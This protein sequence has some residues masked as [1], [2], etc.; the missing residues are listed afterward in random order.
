LS[1][2]VSR[3]QNLG[4]LAK[5][6]N[7]VFVGC[8]NE[9]N[10]QESVV[11]RDTGGTADLRSSQSPE[12]QAVRFAATIDRTN[13]AHAVELLAAGSLD[14]AYDLRHLPKQKIGTRTYAVSLLR[15][16]EQM[17]GVRLTLL[18]REP[19][20]ADGF[21]HRIVTEHEWNDDV[22]VIHRPAQIFDVCDL[23]LLFESS[24]HLVITYQDLIAYRIPH[25]FPSDDEHQKYRATSCLSLPGM[26]GIITYSENAANEIV[27]E[28]GI[29]RDEVTVTPLGVDVDHFAR[30]DRCDS[31]QLKLK[32]LPSRFYFSVATDYPHKNLPGLLE[33]YWMFRRRWHEG[34]PPELIL[35]GYATS[36]RS[37]LYQSISSGGSDNGVRFLGPV[38]ADQ[39]RLLYQNAEAM[40]FPSLYEGFGLPPLEAMAAG[41]PVIAMPFSSVPEVGD[42]CLL[43][44]DGLSSEALAQAMFR[45]S[46]DERLRDDLR[47]R[48]LERVKEFQWEKTA[49][50]TLEVYRSAVLRPSARSLD[51]RRRLRDVILRWADKPANETSQMGIRNAW[52]A[53]NVAVQRRVKN[54]VRR[55]R[56]QTGRRSA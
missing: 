32:G 18:V 27:E 20:Q 26:Q 56:P 4:F 45:L 40:I 28:F 31:I 30:R 38:S 51:A 48:G 39:L 12:P 44:P 14:V 41:T 2:W 15:A 25:V 21:R 16:M 11:R 23:R 42:D 7:R 50:A 6:A 24:A 3:A 22:A 37:G 55:I 8:L 54:E 29:P 1:E 19:S 46:S 36:A 9:L 17:A 52:R 13:V 49:R 10:D 5:R 43:Y 33:A 53:L 47:R 35:A 34:Q